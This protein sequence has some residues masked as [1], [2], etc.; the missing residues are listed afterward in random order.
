ML[1]EKDELL[2]DNIRFKRFNIILQSVLL[3]WEEI[4][5]NSDLDHILDLSKN[6]MYEKFRS[7]NAEETDKM[8]RAKCV[9]FAFYIIHCTY[10]NT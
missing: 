6:S 3:N 8:I 4:E 9:A 5:S 10:D 7:M 2:I 1:L